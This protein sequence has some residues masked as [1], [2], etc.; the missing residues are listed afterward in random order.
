MSK[1]T[2]TKLASFT[3]VAFGEK[4]VL[5]LPYGVKYEE[6]ILETDLSP[7][8]VKKVILT[9][10]GDEIVNVTG[11]FLKKLE[12]YK[13]QKD[14]AAFFVIPLCDVSAK[15]INGVRYSGLATERGD[16]ITLEVEIADSSEQK[17][18]KLKAYAS[19]TSNDPA[20]VVVPQIKQQI[21][22]ASG[23]ENEFLELT[24]SPLLHVRRIHFMSEHIT[25]L[26]IYRDFVREY[27]STKQI[28][29]MRAARLDK[30]WQQGIYHFDPVVRGF[31]IDELF[32][33]AHASE[34]KFTVKT[35]Q[36]CGSI[37]LYVE[38]VKVVRPELM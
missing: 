31:M 9:L 26:D 15:T 28:D 24:A 12:A 38:S 16:N 14:T 30:T 21:M 3:G 8:Q 5:T 22:Q 29:T 17:T 27:E 18:P 32:P 25:G 1:T 37:P 34:L 33:T 13:Q 7:Q 19:I 35:S 4:P 11:E 36:P 2:V 10:N 23:T 20:R 6:L